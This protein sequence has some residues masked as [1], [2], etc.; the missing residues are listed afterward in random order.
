[1]KNLIG[2]PRSI[3]SLLTVVL[4]IGVQDGSYSQSPVEGKIYWTEARDLGWIQRADLD[5]A[6]VV[7]FD[8]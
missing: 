8:R 5:G 6:N 3:A 4:A 1:M 2:R 7:E